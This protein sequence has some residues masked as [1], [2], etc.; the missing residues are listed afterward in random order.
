MKKLGLV[1]AAFGI[2]IL[3]NG[4]IDEKAKGILDKMSDKYQKVAGSKIKFSFKVEDTDIEKATKQ[5]LT[6]GTLK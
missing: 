5:T 6:E 1:I 3:A 2:A 4:Q